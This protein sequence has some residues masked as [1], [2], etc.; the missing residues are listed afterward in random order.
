[1][2][3]FTGFIHGSS[4]LCFLPRAESLCNHQRPL[5][6]EPPDNEV[7]YARQEPL[8]DMKVGFKPMEAA[9]RLLH[10]APN[11]SDRSSQWELQH[12]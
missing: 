3:L 10:L 12:F 8:V 11:F 2:L 4:I 7:H 6:Q 5:V 9:S 1:M